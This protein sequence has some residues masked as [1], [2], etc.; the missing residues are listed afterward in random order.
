MITDAGM[1]HNAL[2]TFREKKIRGNFMMKILDNENEKET[3]TVAGPLCTP[4]DILGRNVSLSKAD[5]GDILCI[6]NSGAYGS[7]FSP[8]S[9]LGHPTPGEILIYNNREYYLKKH[10]SI[11]DILSGQERVTL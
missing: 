2:S 4:D 3:V 5:R 6:L 9:F 10:G 11:Q 7:S 8:L 1:N